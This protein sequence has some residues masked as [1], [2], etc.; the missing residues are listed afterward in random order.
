ML[1]QEE[2]DRYNRQVIL[3][4]FGKEGQEKLKTTR[5]LVVG[6]GGL[7]CPV[8]QYLA[9][10]GVGK[11]G[12]I[13]ADKVSVSNL[14]RQILYREDEIGL[15]KAKLA[16]NK[17]S[18]LN[19]EVE[20]VVSTDFLTEDNAEAIISEYDIVVGATDNF[21]SRYLIDKY[22]QLQNK[23]F[24][25]GSVADFEGQYS[26]FNYQG[27]P[28]YSDVFPSAPQD[29]GKVLGVIGAVPGIIGSYM[30]WEVL[31][32]AAQLDGVSSDALCI[33]KGLEN[34]VLKMLY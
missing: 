31:K 28:A 24:V 26:V 23:P 34:R 27:S 25:H 22:T 2:L 14:Q 15:Y 30:A 29:N 18:K 20:Y 32:I 5:V 16:A 33:Y 3:P 21:N 9:G 17:L 11:I 19:S 6:A 13:D 12:I 1:K 10:A 4:G 8:L 7:G